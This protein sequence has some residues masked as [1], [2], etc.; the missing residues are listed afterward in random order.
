V[1][2]A[3]SLVS[4]VEERFLLPTYTSRWR[5]APILAHRGLALPLQLIGDVRRRQL[6]VGGT[7]VSMIEVGREELLRPLAVRLFGE[8]P[9]PLGKT[10]RLLWSPGAVAQGG[11]ADIILAEVHRW[12]A[13]R[14]RRAGWVI[15][16]QSVRWQGELSDLP[17]K[18]CI[19]GL[20][21]NLR[22]F[23][24]QNFALEQA[25]SSADWDE[26]YRTMVGPQALVRQGSGGW[27]PSRQLMDEFRQVGILHFIM[28]DGQRVAGICTVPRGETLWLAIS[29]VRQGNAGLLRQ[30]A[31]FAIL[32][33]TSEW[34]RAQGYRFLDAG[35]TGP[36]VHDALQ[37][38]K[39]KWGLTPV[40][41]P[42]AHV[43][44]VWAGSPP[45]R[46]ALARQPVLVESGD[47]LRVYAGE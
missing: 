21:E 24:R 46:E 27:I 43:A 35:R 13:P 31:S 28:K 47:E 1:S 33:L 32:A 18:D 4:R 30:G 42:L 16:P 41:D 39:R 7:W 9:R 15:I 6:R 23:R 3:R 12:M 14:F 2:N 22:K 40:P 44:A 26:F 34:S 36:F 19:H 10:R 37:Q 25:S 38:F 17:P 20:L 29:G 8:L 5:R 45:V 11:G